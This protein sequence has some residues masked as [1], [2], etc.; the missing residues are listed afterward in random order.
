LTNIF[1]GRT[2]AGIAVAA[3]RRG[4]AV[5]LLTSHPEAVAE[6]G[7]HAAG[8]GWEVE[9]YHTFDDLQQ[10]MERRITAGALDAVIHCAAVSDYLCAGVYSPDAQTDFDPAALVWKAEAPQGPRLVD[11]QAG[12][13]K[14]D[15]EELWLRLVRAPKLV[16]RV[17]HDWGF[18]GVLVKFKL[19]VDVTD[20]QLLAIAEASRTA[21]Q[22]DLMVA[23]TLEGAASYAF[24]GPLA[25]RYERISRTDLPQRL[26]SVV[27]GLR[28][29]S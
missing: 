17:R 9:P 8:E 16:D 3:H 11:R 19:E 12:K 1:T 7:G 20:E 2:G 14:S 13:V 21:S 26:L 18:R 22:A 25:G 27:E 28:G 15:A 24:L 6:V 5:A 10:A 4:H 23:N 29:R